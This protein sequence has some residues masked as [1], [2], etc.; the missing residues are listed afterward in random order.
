MKRILEREHIIAQLNKME[1]EGELKADNLT[2][3]IFSTD[4]SAYREKPLAVLF[5]KSNSDIEKII[6]F[7]RRFRRKDY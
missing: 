1:F 7:A 2:T 4:A 6:H 5:P 3:S